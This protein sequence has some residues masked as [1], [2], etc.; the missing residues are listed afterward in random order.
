ME[1]LGDILDMEPEQKPEE[2]SSRV[3]LP[4]LQGDIRLDGVYFRYGGNESA[5]EPTGGPNVVE[6][7]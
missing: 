1:R 6:I 2:I 4:D 3:M 7:S 5:L